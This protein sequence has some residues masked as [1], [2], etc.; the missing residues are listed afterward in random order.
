MHRSNRNVLLIASH[1]SISGGLWGL[2]TGIV[3]PL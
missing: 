3:V 1:V 2:D